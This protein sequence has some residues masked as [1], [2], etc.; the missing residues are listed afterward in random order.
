MGATSPCRSNEKRVSDSNKAIRRCAGQSD[1]E[2]EIDLVPRRQF[3]GTSKVQQMPRAAS[4]RK[5]ARILDERIPRFAQLA[6]DK[7]C[8]LPR[9][10]VLAS[11]GRPI[12][13]DLAA[14]GPILGKL[15]GPGKLDAR[16][17]AV[18]GDGLGSGG[19]AQEDYG[20]EI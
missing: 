13:R 15:V 9:E 16:I 12:R 4:L 7:E 1:R 19:K 20:G 10:C 17:I 14:T 2:V 11:D 8:G 3:V 18:T 6:V 5:I